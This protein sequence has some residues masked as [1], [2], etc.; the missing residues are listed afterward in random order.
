MTEL[1]LHILDIALNSTAAKADFISIDI[2]A[3]TKSN[4]LSFSITDNG[5]GISAEMLSGITDP[6]C[7]TRTTRKVGM[8][9]PLLKLACESADGNLNIDSIKGKGTTVKAIFKLNHIDRMPLGDLGETYTALINNSPSVRFLLT[10]E[11]DGQ[12]FSVDTNEIK[13]ALGGADLLDLQACNFIKEMINE[14]ITEI[15]GRNLL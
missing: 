15:C 11:F 7:T 10:F 3:D 5:A 9:I 14:N 13:E 1:S 6:F 2:F 4:V 8:G 12:T